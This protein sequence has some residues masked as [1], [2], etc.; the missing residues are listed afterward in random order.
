MALSF[1]EITQ[2]QRPQREALAQDR[3]RQLRERQGVA[4]KVSELVADP[5]WEV[6]GRH[7]EAMRDKAKDRLVSVELKL[8]G[9]VLSPDEYVSVK[10][11]QSSAR[12]EVRAYNNA[13]ALAKTLI[14][15]GEQAMK[16]LNLLTTE[17]K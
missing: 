13:L 4:Q 16:E 17:D 12:G 8:T 15:Q 9:E 2:Q 11:S 5:R 6:W 7:L 1:E 10:V 3:L 14:E